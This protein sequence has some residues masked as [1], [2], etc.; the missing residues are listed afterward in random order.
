MMLNK[1]L[2]K[3]GFKPYFYKLQD[4]KVILYHSFHSVLLFS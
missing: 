2:N 1:M 4:M 3:V